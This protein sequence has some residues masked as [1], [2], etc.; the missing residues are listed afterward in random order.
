[1]ADI[2]PQPCLLCG[3][4]PKVDDFLLMTGR[5]GWTALCPNRCYETATYYERVGAVVDW[6]AWVESEGGIFQGEV[7]P[8]FLD[9]WEDS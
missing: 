1:M 8:E 6:N 3:E 7:L 2:E 9:E 5:R 4:L